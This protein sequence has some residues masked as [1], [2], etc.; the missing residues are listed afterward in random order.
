M[1]VTK[2]YYSRKNDYDK[3]YQFLVKTYESGGKYIN[4]LPA[5]WEYMHYH[6]YYNQSLT[7]KSGIWE[8]DGKI[9]AVVSNELGNGNAFFQCHPDYVSLK[10]EML[11]HAEEHFTKEEEAAG[12][13]L[14][15]YANDFDE[16]WM[17]ILETEGYEKLETNLQHQTICTIDRSQF[18]NGGTVPEGFE[19]KSLA[20][21][22]DLVKVDRVQWRGFNHEGEPP[23]ESPEERKLMQSAP[24]FRKDLT[25][26][27]VAPNGE[28][29]SYV[30]MWFIDEIKVGYVE[31]VCTDPDYRRL[32]LGK[33]TLLESMDRCFQMGAE[34]IVVESSLP[35]YLSSGFQ[36]QFIRYPW[37]KRK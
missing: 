17:N 10:K 9:V 28:F 2:R 24:N 6:S 13:R 21:D 4:W 23:K 11:S 34:R 36:P 3:V 1:S 32:G 33:R 7:E 5:R 15:V 14:I 35:I 16:E 26:V 37:V 29:V 18:I 25:I 30:G 27:A 12:H 8:D 22:N 20:E 19:L 31:P